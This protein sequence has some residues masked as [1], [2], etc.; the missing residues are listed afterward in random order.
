MRDSSISKQ[1]LQRLPLY[2]SH[3][4]G[5]PA[6]GYI[7][8]TAIAD[9]LGYN[10]VQVRKDL[11]SVSHSG[12]PK[13]GYATRDLIQD[14]EHS[15]GYNS[16]HKAVLVGAGKLGSALLGYAGFT[17]Y[18]L[19]IIMAFDE[20]SE[21]F[22]KEISGCPVLPAAEIEEQCAHLGASIGI[23][24]VPAARAQAVCDQLVAGGI[25]A[26]W[27]FAPV[28]LIVPEDILVQNENMASSLAVLS[29]HLADKRSR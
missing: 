28:K 7:S 20:N 17:S 27:N 16:T 5:L 26:I 29:Q 19:N 13:V 14:I 6:D 3:L 23:I 2:L 4:K 25:E 9:A 1:T 21:L 22:G 8:A 24:T 18:G 12:R 11:A 10:H 15:L